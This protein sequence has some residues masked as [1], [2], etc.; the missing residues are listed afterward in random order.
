MADITEFPI[1]TQV[2]DLDRVTQDAAAA[3]AARG[4]S[5]AARDSSFANAKG[6]ATIADAR[7]LVADTETF[8][9]YASGAETFEAYR[10]ESSSTETLLGTYPSS[11]LVATKV[12]ATNA[13][14]SFTINATIDAASTASNLVLT[15]PEMPTSPTVG[16]RINVVLDR[17]LVPSSGEVV[18]RLKDAA[19]T[20][21]PAF[22]V[23]TTVNGAVKS[24]LASNR[25]PV[26][27]TWRGA[28]SNT[29]M[30]GGVMDQLYAK[31]TTKHLNVTAVGGTGNAITLTTDYLGVDKSLAI[32]RPPSANTIATPT[33]AFT[34]QFGATQGPT[35]LRMSDLSTVPVGE[36]DPSRYV[37]VEYDATGG[38]PWRIIATSIAYSDIAALE[39]ELELLETR[40]D[41]VEASVGSSGVFEAEALALMEK[42]IGPLPSA[43]GYTASPRNPNNFFTWDEGIR[44]KAAATEIKILNFGCS[45]DNELHTGKSPSALVQTA[46]TDTFAY[47]RNLSFTRTSVAV[48]GDF[49]NEFLGQ[50]QGAAAGS[51]DIVMGGQPVN[52][53][54]IG[55]VAGVN[56]FDLFQGH[57]TA[58]VSEARDVRNAMPMLINCYHNHVDYPQSVPDSYRSSWPKNNQTYRVTGNHTFDAAANT[59]QMINLDLYGYTL[60]AGDILNVAAAGGTN[61]GEHEIVSIDWPNNRVTVDGTITES[62]TFNVL[63]QNVQVDEERVIWPAAS[64]LLLM[65][66]RLGDG[67]RT[68]GWRPT[69]M[70]NQLYTQF[71]NAN[72][73]LLFDMQK[74]QQAFFRMKL[75][76]NPTWTTT[77]LFDSMFDWVSPPGVQFN[78]ANE[79]FFDW[80]GKRFAGKLT[81]FIED[82]TLHKNRVIW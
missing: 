44:T 29:Y 59:I 15:A 69:D 70:V 63:V 8:I 9:V 5:E 82:G 22:N 51:F 1:Q 23:R 36:L 31:A 25:S 16:M 26:S 64:E 11:A 20:I 24:G 55:A 65:R 79:E 53:A 47:L 52:S 56:D 60:T 3:E 18:V 81:T 62:G 17:N 57:L 34:D 37:I 28:P 7:A 68:L 71:C 12:S 48:G 32:F 6:A 33:I 21:G 54:S 45:T 67:V 50:I 19:G 27:F 41:V 58:V 38:N 66:D 74:A 39:G 35:A 46:L 75:E 30:L 72:G 73:V 13:R 80:A 4:L 43:A 14:A 78:H 2:I 10:R 61:T 40:L 76:A 49:L 42:I 77:Q